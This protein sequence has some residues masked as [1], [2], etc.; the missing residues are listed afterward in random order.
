[1][2]I[3]EYKCSSCGVVMEK[4]RKVEDKNSP[5]ACMYCDGATTP[6]EFPTSISMSTPGS[7]NN[8]ID[9][10]IGAASEK[11][12]ER[13][14]ERKADRDKVRVDSNQNGLSA[15]PSGTI[16]PITEEKKRIRTDVLTMLDKGG[17][18]YI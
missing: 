12:H 15:T 13:I 14:R 1:M 11:E 4:V 9:V 5:L 7:D 3:F 10:K 2:P 18:K 8:V 16:K 17:N 6:L